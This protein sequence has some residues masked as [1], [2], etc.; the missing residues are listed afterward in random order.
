MYSIFIYILLYDTKF[1]F[2]GYESS[3]KTTLCKKIDENLN[4]LWVSEACRMAAEEKPINPEKIDFHFTLDD[5]R[6]MAHHQNEIEYNLQ[7]QS[8]K[9]FIRIYNMVRV[10]FGKILPKIL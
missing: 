7:K 8:Q 5:F 6:K 2:I 3:G 1:I 10:I 4:F 9:R